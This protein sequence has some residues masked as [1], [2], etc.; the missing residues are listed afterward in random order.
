MLSLYIHIHVPLSSLDDG[1]RVA[2]MPA[3][4][5]YYA[6]FIK[7]ML[8]RLEEEASSSS[9][10]NANSRKLPLETI[11]KAREY[12]LLADI[13]AIILSCYEPVPVSRSS[14]NAFLAV[15]HLRRNEPENCLELITEGRK[16][17]GDDVAAVAGDNDD[18]SKKRSFV[19][20]YATGMEEDDDD[21]EDN[22]E[23][24]DYHGGHEE[25]GEEDAGRSNT[26]ARR[27]SDT[28]KRTSRFVGW[29]N[30][31]SSQVQANVIAELK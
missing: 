3:T 20:Y 7:A 21:E 28:Q 18:G 9:Q 17:N 13:Q 24:E 26:G 5:R 1:H 25:E 2:R 11:E 14:L 15:F 8:L 4:A 6:G 19:Y 23:D 16:K 31:L 10:S 27:K 12:F 29:G 30:V 22:S